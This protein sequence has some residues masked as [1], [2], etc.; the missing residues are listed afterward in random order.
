MDKNP[1]RTCVICRA[2]K[3]KEELFRFL[4]E[5]GKVAFDKEQKGI[6][7]GFYICSDKCW[8]SAMKKKRKIRIGSDAKKA[9]SVGLPEKTFE[10]I[11]RV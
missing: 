5:D 3:R 9:I 7:R 2:K 4:V 11:T 1:Q 8:D 10:E 6:G